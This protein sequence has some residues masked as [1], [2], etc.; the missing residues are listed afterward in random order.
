MLADTSLKTKPSES[1]QNEKI[2]VYNI[3][4]IRCA[5][6]E[7]FGEFVQFIARGAFYG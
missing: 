4:L 3:L 7:L 1:W 5:S 2:E 6:S